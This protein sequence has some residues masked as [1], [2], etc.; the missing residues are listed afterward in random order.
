MDKY[1]KEK[2]SRYGKLVWDFANAKTTDDILISFFKNLQAAFDFS[3]DFPEKALTQYPTRQ[4]MTGTLSSKEQNLFEI[5]LQ[6]NKALYSCQEISRKDY[7]CNFDKYDHINFVFI[8]LERHWTNPDNEFDT[9]HEDK[10]VLISEKEINKYI[11]NMGLPNDEWEKELRSNLKQLVTLCHRIEEIKS[12]ATSRFP[13]I[14]KIAK[15][16]PGISLLHYRLGEIQRKLKLILSQIMEA[17]NTYE[18]HGFK[19]I[20]LQYNTIHKTKCIVNEDQKLVQIDPFIEDDFFYSDDVDFC[21]LED[22]R[23]KAPTSYC[24]VEF[25]KHPEYSG[26]QRIAVCQNCHCIFGKSKLNGHQIYCPV[27]SRKNKMTPGERADYMKQYRANPARRR[28]IE[29]EKRETEIQHLMANAGKTRKQ[30][31]FI[32]DNKM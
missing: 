15:I 11:D 10:I 27:C 8:F 9:S 6:R 19:S 5:L 32:V 2:L 28:A 20:L 1:E 31:E 24:L 4:M 7:C 26:K 25:L 3:K 21:E 22:Q 18:T 13:E 29:R 14:E 23:F 12:E 17:D 30:A 16:Y